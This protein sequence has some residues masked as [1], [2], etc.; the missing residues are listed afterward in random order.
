MDRDENFINDRV[1]GM[2]QD[3]LAE[4]L[5][6]METQGLR[7]TLR[8][9]DGA[10]DRVVTVDGKTYL[11]F[12]SNDYLGLANDERIKQA[13]IAAIKEEGFGA[14][15][16]RLVCGNFASHRRLEEELACFKKTP[17]CLVFGSGYAANVGIISSLYGKDDV[18][19][20]DRLNHASIVDGIILSRAQLWRYP[21]NDM[22]ALEERLKSASGFRKKLIVTDTVFSM[23]GDLAP[24]D[25]ITAL[26]KQ[27]DC[28]V[29][30]DEAHALGVLGEQG[31]GAVEHFMLE[32][33]IDI[34]M[35]TLSKAAGGLGAYC[36]GSTELAE[37]LINKARSFIYTTAL[38]PSV[39]ATA[40]MALKIIQ[41]EPQRRAR[42]WEN[43]RY[44]SQELR[45]LGFDTM[46]SV[47][48]IIP[49]L[50]KDTKVA[51]SLSRQLF[52]RGILVAAIRP[53]TVPEGRARLRVTVTA[54]HT[55]EDFDTAL[56]KIKTAGKTL[57][58]I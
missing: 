10:Q 57:C 47:T 50:V 6:K 56:E 2:L 32:G 11:N 3:F 38:P 8:P 48:P 19:F 42:L 34:Q 46:A 26:A 20:S 33:K 22:V 45:R 5:A 18:I 43:A 14:G 44:F 39:A 53:P 36:C 54:A 23:D 12:C 49:I 7:R 17:R 51:M 28:A 24:L 40:C 21:H 37:F 16:A 29:M 55:R 31:R 4:T 58:L 1:C 9:I 30:V 27:Y 52:E 35:G 15:A 13:A 25:R 41:N